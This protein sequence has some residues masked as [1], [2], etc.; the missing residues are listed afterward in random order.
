M[1]FFLQFLPTYVGCRLHPFQLLE[2]YPAC[3]ICAIRELGMAET[4]SNIVWCCDRRIVSLNN[5]G[6]QAQRGPS[7][8]LKLT[9]KYDSDVL[10]VMNIR[11]LTYYHAF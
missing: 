11:F 3:D 10:T 6:A 9:L 7:N 4:F 1:S 8:S 5:T 2:F